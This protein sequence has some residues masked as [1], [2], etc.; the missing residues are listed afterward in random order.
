MAVD[1]RT[2]LGRLVAERMGRARVFES[3]GLDYCCQGGRTLAEA[4]DEAGLEVSRVVAALETS[5]KADGADPE[6]LVDYQAMPLGELCDHIV[7]THHE[8]MRRELPRLR[9]LLNRVR[10]SHQAN[11]PE[12]AS[13]AAVLAGLEGEIDMHLMKEEQVLFPLI[14]K[15][16]RAEAMPSFHCGSV[17]NP[18][19]VMEHEHDEV[20]G[21]LTR[22]RELTGGLAAP[23]DGCA[24]YQA[25]IDG[26]ADLERDLHRHIHKENNVL[27]VRAAALEASLAAAV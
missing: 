14:K 17:N 22:I 10:G 4:C 25:L 2:T 1:E 24:S 21:A 27:H 6:D 26:L 8:F 18:I 16:E 19:R 5:D 11:H 15:L 13:L 7:S 9:A 23:A 12:L 20:G 3:M